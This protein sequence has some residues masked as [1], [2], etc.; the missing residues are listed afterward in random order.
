MPLQHA[1][2]PRA[3]NAVDL[4]AAPASLKLT[5]LTMRFSMTA[6]QQAA[7]E[8]LLQDQQNPKSS[9]Y[10]QWLT[11]QQFGAQFGLSA[12]DIAKVSAWL[13]SKGF[14]VTGVAKSSTFITFS[15]TAAQVQQAFGTTIHNLS[16]NGQKHIANL[17]DPSLPPGI[18]GVVSDITGLNDFKPKPRVR[19]R[20]LRANTQSGAV[21][22]NNTITLQDGTTEHFIA[23]GDFYTIYG[24]SSLISN[25]TNGTGIKIAVM[26]QVD[27]TN[28]LSDVAAFRAASGLSSNVPTIQ[29]YGTNPGPPSAACL[30]TNPPSNC[31]PSAN[32]L[33]ESL[34]D[35]EWA[36]AAAPG[37][38]IIFVNSQNVIA[39]SLAQ[40]I[41][42]N[43]APIMTVSYGACENA[44]AP[45]DLTAFNQILMQGNSQGISIFSSSG[46]SGATDCDYADTSA[47]QGLSV[48]YPTSSPYV[49]SVGGLTFNEGG[50]TSYWSST[51]GAYGGSATGYI[52][53]SVWNE[54]AQRST[55]SS[56]GGG[57]S[58]YFAKPY[59]QIG[60]GVPND[61]SRDV[62]D[63][64]LNAAVEHDGYLVCVQGSCAN[65]KYY[66]ANGN[67]EVFGGTSAAA[68]SFAGI[69]AVVQQ[70]LGGG[71]LGNINPNL[72]AAANSTF[73]NNIFHDVASGDNKSPC[74]AGTQDC[75]IGGT[76]GY[77]AGPGYDLAS[78]WGS[79]N[80]AEL[81]NRWTSIPPIS[82]S[83]KALSTTTLTANPTAGIAGAAISLTIN[84]AAGGSSASVPTGSVQI[85][86][87]GTAVPS[88]TTALTNGNATYSL[89]TTGLRSG[90]HD[91][92]AV[93]TGDSTYDGSKDTVQIDITS[94]TSPDFTITPTTASVATKS[95]TTAQG[96]TFN[97]TPVNGFTGT[98][99]LTLSAD[100]S[101]AASYAFS[102]GD[103]VTISSNAAVPTTLT[104]SAFQSNSS[105]SAAQHRLVSS[106][107]PMKQL[108]W[109][110]TGSGVTFAC[111]FLI[112][113]PRRRK[114]GA[115]LAV[116][117]SVGIIGASGC[118][119]SSSLKLPPT[120]QPTVTNA[121]PGTYHITITAITGSGASTLAHTA[122]VT[123]T[124][125]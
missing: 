90:T 97:L 64:A 11:P 1:V 15:G 28:F 100:Q 87:D 58:A 18:A 98:V 41:D 27:I 42:N 14:T 80:V 46:D 47:T 115:L 29:L 108:P 125:Q 114:W 50:S 35:V 101:V 110:V 117:V 106:N 59:W 94:A 116:I 96:I 71:R 88:S 49:T 65:G 74:T 12:A 78:G 2:S 8:Q 85:L 123:F 24:L 104:L 40:A 79:V 26:G 91:I 120:T 76:I 4:G 36:G 5:G 103:S 89:N 10:H 105:T 30:G 124:V 37:A 13:T 22:A 68:P 57:A 67:F 95:G 112:V 102:T 32:D 6:A 20:S 62:P 83:N 17:T 48:D 23:P 54:T 3:K 73:Y 43:I 113:V 53:E 19:T 84:V 21:H 31:I 7:L 16:V 118:S 93:Y 9:R 86:V 119:Q 122:T 44:F 45:S 38:Q 39:N 25:S 92:A 33:D 121:A 61:F 72:Y 51:N 75:P 99:N 109:Y 111:L 60:S 81:A 66:N 69:M 52:P 56:G 77:T 34:L 82:G 63:V 70:S 107:R 55:F